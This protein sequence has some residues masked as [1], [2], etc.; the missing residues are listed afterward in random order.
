M[1]GISWANPIPEDQMRRTLLLCALL[2]LAAAVA[3]QRSEISGRSVR[4]GRSAGDSLTERDPS[5]SPRGPYHVWTLSGKKGQR[6]VIDMASSAFDPYLALRDA[7]G[8]LLARDDDGGE[9]LA[10]RLRVVLPHSG[11][12]RLVATSINSTARGWYTIAV[13]EWAAPD[14]PAPGRV[15]AIAGGETKTG[16]LEPGDEQAG[17]GPFQD[18]WT[19]EARSGQRL[20]VEMSSTDLDSYLTILGPDGAVVASNDDIGGGTDA[21]VNFTAQAAGRFT[22][23]AS[24]YGDQ[25]GFGAYRL[26]A[27]EA[28]AALGTPGL[29][30]LADG[31]TAEGRLEEGDSVV[32]GG[33]VDV[34]AYTPAR[35][36]TITFDLR[37]AQF[38]AILSLEDES[39][40]EIARDDD[41]G[42]GTDSRLVFE[43]VAGRRYL[44]R[45]GAFGTM[46]R[47]GAYTLS[48]R[49]NATPT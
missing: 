41:G 34:Y 6:L 19:I 43:V 12:Y 17:D 44:L 22:V 38:D 4:V 49:T 27:G 5:R 9:G 40:M 14:A 3:C 26:T 42:G 37:S 13:S 36:G 47:G 39:G 35:A 48:V 20:R 18:R 28:P 45:V 10:A 25:P 33:F 2:P 1:H 24:S 46:Q 29:T 11:K 7:E 21:A 32:G 23:L 8:F 15:S 16:L 30:P 31:A